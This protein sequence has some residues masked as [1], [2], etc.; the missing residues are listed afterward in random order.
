[1]G[2]KLRRALRVALGAEVAGLQRAVA[3]EIADD[4]ND[5]TR[6]SSASLEDLA[7]WTAAKDVTVVRTTLKR[8]S[9]AGWEF[10]VP[11]GKGKDGRVLY[12]VP[13]RRLTFRVPNFEEV[14]TATPKGEPPLPLPPEGGTTGRPKG[15]PALLQG[16]TT[17]PTEGTVVPSEGTPV[18]PF[19]SIPSVP[20]SLS[21][22][23]E[24][25]TMAAPADEREKSPQEVMHVR[26]VERS[27]GHP[28]RPVEQTQQAQPV[29]SESQAEGARQVAAAYSME[30]R[31]HHLPTGTGALANVR[32]EAEQL[33]AEGLPAEWLSDRAREMAR[34]GWSRLREHCE[35]STVPVAPAVAST[36]PCEQCAGTGTVTDDND[37]TTWCPNCKPNGRRPAQSHQPGRQRSEEVLA[38][39][40]LKQ[41]TRRMEAQPR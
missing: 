17:A 22:P 5:V 8:L 36:G 29:I 18:T 19:S 24:A 40:V 26:P 35:R 11:L 7:L 38:G 27:S 21:V 10:R 31:L 34:K 6:M 28:R 15:E 23:A 30:R 9:A 37:V 41:I 32:R 16:V 39:D 4:A 13:G 20:S 25:P 33:L 1:M 14:S 12:A 2:Y 3:L